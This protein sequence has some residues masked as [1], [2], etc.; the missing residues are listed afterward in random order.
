M[1]TSIFFEEAVIYL[2]WYKSGFESICLTFLGWIIIYEYIFNTFRAVLFC[3]ERKHYLDIRSPMM[4]QKL[5]VCSLVFWSIF[6]KYYDI[7]EYVNVEKNLCL[8]D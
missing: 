3:S 8:T 6:N 4:E 1:Q 7:K 5:N 2:T